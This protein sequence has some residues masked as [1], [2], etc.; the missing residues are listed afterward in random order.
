MPTWGMGNPYHYRNKLQYPIGVNKLGKPIIGVFANRTHEIISVDNCLIQNEKSN[1]VAKYVL[2][3]IEKYK[4]SIYNEAT[5]EGLLRH[6]VIKNAFR[7][8]EIMVILVINGDF[9]PFAKDIVQDLQGACHD[10]YSIVVNI[11]KKNTNVILGNKNINLVGKG[12]IQ[13]ILGDYI[14]NI[15]PLS[16]YQVNPVQAEALYNIAIENAKIKAIDVSKK[17]PDDTIIGADTIVT[18]GSKIFGKPDGR[19]GAIMMLEE[20]QNRT[21]SV[22]TG[23]AIVN[24]GKIF[25]ASETTLVTFGV[26]TRGE[27][28]SF[29]D[30][31]EPMDKSGSYALQ[32]FTAPFI[33]KIDGDWSN[34]V[35]LPLYQLRILLKEVFE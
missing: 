26:M 30:T 9:L 32:G 7:T 8:N 5:H 23:L 4:L 6:V 1:Q 16:F 34:V 28:E 10:I 2:D 21:H 20:L 11:N 35:G 24:D 18:L 29:V 22:I 17:F 15:S 13:D 25:T 12:Y 33:R 27:I 14:F 3:V 31:G 19:N